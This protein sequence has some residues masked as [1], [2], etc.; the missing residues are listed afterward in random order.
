[1]DGVKFLSVMVNI[2]GYVDCNQYDFGAVR[3]ECENRSYILGVV[4]SMSEQ[5][6]GCTIIG[7]KLEVDKEIFDE[8][9]TKYDLTIYDLYDS[10]LKATLYIGEEC[11]DMPEHM[12][13]FVKIGD[14]TKAIDLT[15]E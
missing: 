12:T 5:T 4:S 1:M 10:N 14:C 6:D 7:L 11:Y 13:L 2:D 3:L 15:I 8:T 9:H